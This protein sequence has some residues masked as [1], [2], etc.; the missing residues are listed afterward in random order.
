[1]KQIAIGGVQFHRI[2]TGL[3]QPPRGGHEILLNFGDLRLFQRTHL[4][5]R[6]RVAPRRRPNRFHIQHH[7][8]QQRAAVINLP[9]R[10]ATMPLDAFHQP[11]QAGDEAVMINPE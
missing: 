2:I 3:P 11:R 1:M 8:A 4:I 7:P 9:H 10:H 5:T 6:I